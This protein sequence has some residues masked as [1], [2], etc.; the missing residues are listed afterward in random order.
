M[1]ERDSRK[2]GKEKGRKERRRKLGG[3]KKGR[4]RSLCADGRHCKG[5][6]RCGTPTLC[7][8]PYDISSPDGG[9]PVLALGQENAQ[10]SSHPHQRLVPS[11]PTQP[12]LKPRHL[13]CVGL[14]T[15]GSAWA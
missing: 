12:D 13:T 7:S 15:P 3:R 8:S 1:E 9:G 11:H 14:S 10:V 2:G 5:C 4:R 6:L